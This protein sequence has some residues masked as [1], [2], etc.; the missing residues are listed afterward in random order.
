VREDRAAADHS[1]GSLLDL[2]NAAKVLFAPFLPHTSA[3]L[4]AMLGY[5][6][7]LESAGWHFEP[8]PGG[9]QLPVPKPLFRKL[10][11]SA[12]EAA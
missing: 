10:E 12:A 3:A 4:H 9:R 8:L 6:D 5:A 11:I 1:M 2:I 7:A